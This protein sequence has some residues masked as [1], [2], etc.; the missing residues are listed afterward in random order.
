MRDS[1][2]ICRVGSMWHCYRVLGRRAYSLFSGTLTECRKWAK[3]GGCQLE[4]S[5]PSRPW[6]NIA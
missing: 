1:V 4:Q 5:Q 2:S 3:E 6:A